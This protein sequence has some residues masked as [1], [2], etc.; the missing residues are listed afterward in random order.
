MAELSRRVTRELEEPRDTYHEADRRYSGST[1]LRDS[2][3]ATSSLDKSDSD[4]SDSDEEGSTDEESV[5]GSDEDA[6]YD[7]FDSGD[8]FYYSN[9][10]GYRR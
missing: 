3:S 7:F 2:D 1:A 5:D 8:V 10:A 4:F 9:A 6:S